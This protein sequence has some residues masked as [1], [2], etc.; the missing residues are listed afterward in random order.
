MF[1]KHL[2]YLTNQQLIAL[3]WRRGLL[4]DSKRFTADGRGQAAFA[5]Y[6]END[7]ALRAYLLTDLIEEDFRVELI[8]HVGPRDRKGLLERKLSQIYRTTPYRH[9]RIQGREAS[10]RKDDRVLYTAIS[11]SELLAP[12]LDILQAHK[13]P[14]VGIYSAPLLAGRLLKPLQLDAKH[15]LLVTLHEGGGLRQSYF[16]SG[17]LKFSRMTP[18]NENSAVQFASFV[19]SEVERTLQ[20]LDSLRYR[21][22]EESLQACVIC[23]RNAVPDF[24]RS[25]LDTPGLHYKFLD[26]GL[27]A[28]S[29]GLK[30]SPPD[31]DASTL[32]LHSVA[33]RTPRN[34]FAQ[35]AQTHYAVL[36]R[37]RRAMFAVSFVIAL[38]SGIAGGGYLFEGHLL[39]GEIAQARLHSQ[40]IEQDRRA[41]MQRLP[42]TTV[43]PDV[44]SNTVSFY[45]DVIANA[46]DFSRFAIELSQ[47][48]NEYNNIRLSKV[49]WAATKDLTKLPAYT[50]EVGRHSDA[51]KSIRSAAGAIQAAIDRVPGAQLAYQGYYQVA[52][53]EGEVTGLRNDYRSAL[54]GIEELIESLQRL[55]GATVSPIVMPLDTSPESILRGK[56]TSALDTGQARFA[57]QLL[58]APSLQ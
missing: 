35:P 31:S 36:W 51:I 47:V 43:A 23:H 53:I 3:V 46:P 6:L 12:W 7:V 24:N 39:R 32:L 58:R 1:R 50:P 5:S 29:I 25:F 37:A 28:K 19:V 44:M 4:A 45:N 10:G 40:S 38:V 20:Y 14:L 21:E 17:H 54:A 55:P 15:V 13:T 57:L 22:A 18:L 56:A 52:M 30:L 48:L 2:F 16:Q 8:P 27:A 11:N 42:T 49:S 41:T 9:A 26:I 34:H 33:Q